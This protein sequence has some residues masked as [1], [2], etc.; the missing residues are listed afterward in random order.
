MEAVFVLPAKESE[1]ELPVF[2]APVALGVCPIFQKQHF[3]KYLG[4]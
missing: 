2:K 1:E 3:T 4:E